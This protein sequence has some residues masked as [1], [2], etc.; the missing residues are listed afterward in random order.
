MTSL[1]LKDLES[2]ADQLEPTVLEAGRAIMAVYETDFDV[3]TKED[4]S[5]VTAADEA[6]EA[7]ILRDLARIAPEI[8]VVAEEQCAAEGFPE[9]EGTTFWCVDAM[10]GTKEF[11]KRRGDFTVNIGL[12]VEGVP[13]L[14]LVYAPVHK[15][16]YR[17]A[18][19]PHTGKRS[20]FVVRDGQRSVLA[21]RDIPSDGLTV[22][23][24]ASHQVKDAMDD[25]LAGQD[26]KEMIAVGSS[27]KFCLVA[28]GKADVYP[29]FGPTCEWDI[30]AGHAVLRAAGGSVK[31]F[32]GDD[33]PYKKE[34]ANYLN[35]TFLAA[36]TP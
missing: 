19:C 35:G 12:L 27:L 5:P 36:S 24:S 21:V 23:G 9:F 25:Y 8:P 32:D 10:D 6:S 31:T 29:R 7:I 33:L 22:V 11:I 30:A 26:V 16:L 4:N 17:G 18:I 34:A 20:A 2:Y 15:T 1:T 14:G 28:E 13:A 3:D